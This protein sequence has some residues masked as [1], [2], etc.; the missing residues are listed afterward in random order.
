MANKSS[1]PDA[2]IKTTRVLLLCSFA[3]GPVYMGVS[4]VQAFT[5]PG[6]DITRHALSALANGKLGWLQ[7]ANFVL[8]GLLIT[9]GAVG[10]RRA[11][12]FPVGTPAEGVAIS[13]IG[14]VHVAFGGA[15]FLAVLVACVVFAHRFS[16]IQQKGWTVLSAAAGVVFLAGFAGLSSGSG[17][18]WTFIGFLIGVTVLW[19]WISLLCAH[20]R[21]EGDLTCDTSVSSKP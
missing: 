13:N 1:L 8:T 11:L 17:K 3:A 2:T 7:I 9:A 18:S 20:L 15:G 4:L 16:V 6:F 14:M 21:P 10:I 5:R 19:S 12:S